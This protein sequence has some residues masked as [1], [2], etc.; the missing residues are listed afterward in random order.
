MFLVNFKEKTVTEV[1]LLKT[2]A[3][4]AHIIQ[5]GNE[6]FELPIEDDNCK[7]CPD[8]RSAYGML[9]GCWVVQND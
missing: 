9:Y 4:S 3:G 1:K 6:I 8:E 5:K 7:L 2:Y